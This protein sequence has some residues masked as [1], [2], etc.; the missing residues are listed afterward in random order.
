[1]LQSLT[2]PRS[3]LLLL[4]LLGADRYHVGKKNYVN[5]TMGKD[6]KKAAKKGKGAEKTAERTDKKAKAKLLKATGED[7]IERMV[8]AIEEEEKRSFKRVQSS[9]FFYSDLYP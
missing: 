1:M 9:Y 2:K 8:S 6:K 5:S 4:L 3:I 7:D